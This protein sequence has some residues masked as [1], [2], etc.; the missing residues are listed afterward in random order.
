MENSS[1]KWK[2]FEHHLLREPFWKY[3]RPKISYFIF[4]KIN[5]KSK[6][7][8]EINRIVQ[9]RLDSKWKGF[10]QVY[11]DGSKQEDKSTGAAFFIDN[12]DVCKY[13]KLSSICIL[14]AELIAFIMG[15]ITTQ[16]NCIYNGSNNNTA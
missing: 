14:R 3:S 11:T 16:L 12:L 6:S 15:H 5:S 7:I 1:E 2:K 10:I 4:N 9:N 8:I 13:F